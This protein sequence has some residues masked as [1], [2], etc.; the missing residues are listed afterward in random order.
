LVL[1][2]QN[3]KQCIFDSYELSGRF[4]QFSLTQYNQL[5]EQWYKVDSYDLLLSRCSRLECNLQCTCKKQG[6]SEIL[7]CACPAFLYTS[8]DVVHA[9][10]EQTSLWPYDSLD[11]WFTLLPYTVSIDRDIPI[12]SMQT[13]TW[14][15][16]S[17]LINCEHS[18][19][20]GERRSLQP[21]P[22]LIP[23]IKV[24]VYV[25]YLIIFHQVRELPQHII[26]WTRRI[27]CLTYRIKSSQN[28]SNSI[29]L[30]WK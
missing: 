19:N 18:T 30:Q 27:Y 3:P 8:N 6:W 20:S 26:L 11:C 9:F 14:E 5:L 1:R 16:R 25:Q 12:G 23:L 29:K 10:A 7:F 4:T 24:R 2:P 22:A 28:M 17:L 15:W 13:S 21:V